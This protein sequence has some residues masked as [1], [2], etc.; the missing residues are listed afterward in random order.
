MERS[1]LR[2]P[3]RR[4]RT[5]ALVDD[6]APQGSRDAAARRR[7]LAALATDP[8]PHEALSDPT[9][10]TASALVVGPRGVLLHHHKRLGR[11][12]QPGGH[13]DAGEQPAA[14]AL[15]EAR[16]ETG[17]PAAHPDDG[18]RLVDVDAHAL[19]GP[20][21]PWQRAGADPAAIT[22][23]HL[24]LRFV[25]HADAAPSPPAGESQDVAWWSWAEALAVADAGLAQALSRLAPRGRA[26]PPT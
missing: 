8:D 15:R 6:Y 26:A 20:C 3:S 13:I 18:P 2:T 10:L 11:W 23:V 1:P 12:L 19:P 7:V 22:C 14:A 21:G 4:A 16:E 17:V 5:R 9:H 25:L 24:D